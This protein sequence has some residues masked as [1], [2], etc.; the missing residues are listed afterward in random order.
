MP[1]PAPHRLSLESYPVRLTLPVRFQDLDPMNHLNNVAISALFE[2]ARVRFNG[3]LGRM[4]GA[5]GFR[6]VV[7][8]NAVNYVAEGGYPADVTIGVGVGHIGNRSYELLAAMVQEGRTIATNDTVIVV[9]DS[10]DGGIPAAY[11]AALEGKRVAE[12]HPA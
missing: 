1:R 12:A 9:T 2:D 8:M 3:T 11:R 7:A 4:N 5:D 6:A 10:P